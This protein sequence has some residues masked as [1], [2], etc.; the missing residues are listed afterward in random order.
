MAEREW[1]DERAGSKAAVDNAQRMVWL[2]C[3]E[4]RE[5]QVEVKPPQRDSLDEGGGVQASLQPA[6][7]LQILVA[8]AG[9][10]VAAPARQWEALLGIGAQLST[11]LLP[12]LPTYPTASLARASS[13]LLHL[14]LGSFEAMLPGGGDAE[15]VDGNAA[16]DETRLEA[17]QVDITYEL[18]AGEVGSLTHFLRPCTAI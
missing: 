4:I 3:C 15:S 9:V 13:L 16:G 11:P 14:S 17:T 8:V 12:Q 2:D 6:T 5:I 7:P 10:E 18:L 1:Q